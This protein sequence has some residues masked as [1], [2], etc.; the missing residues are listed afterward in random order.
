MSTFVCGDLHGNFKALVELL[1]KASFD[2]AVD[3]LITL[4]DYIDGGAHIEVEELIEY[5]LTLPNWIGVIGN[6]DYW[7]LETIIAGWESIIDTEWLKYGG[8]Y[9]L[10]SLGVA[11]DK[12]ERI[13][14]MVYKL[15]QLTYDEVLVVDADTL[16]SKEEYDAFSL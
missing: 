12:E 15:C 6:H 7:M 1:S 2:P 8:V 9:T 16:I 3:T 5:L 14:S 11:Y 13:G 10:R 4:G